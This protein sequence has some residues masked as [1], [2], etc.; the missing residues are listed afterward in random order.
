[1]EE[2]TKQ[3]KQQKE[4]ELS[5]KKNEGK[6]L[7]AS[8]DPIGSHNSLDMEP[9]SSGSLQPFSKGNLGLSNSELQPI[10]TGRYDTSSLSALKRVSCAKYFSQAALD[11]A[12][13][14]KDVK[15]KHL[16]QQAQKVM[17]GQMIDSP[18]QF[19]DLPNVPEVPKPFK[20]QPASS[21]EQAAYYEG[22]IKTVQQKAKKLQGIEMK[23]KQT[24]KK[25]NQAK[26]KKKKAEQKISD[27]KKSTALA[28]NQQKKKETDELEAA[29]QA[30][31]AESNKEIQKANS[32]KQSLL[33]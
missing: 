26:E 21:Q 3:A 23:L 15:A 10:G 5:K 16:N 24:D 13:N 7:L 2:A 17:A 20:V 6:K 22:L 1:M 9:I 29:A 14:G 4:M 8:L 19:S 18:C 28:K 27:I 33:K 11:A 32:A 31:L 30:L 25:L 12:N